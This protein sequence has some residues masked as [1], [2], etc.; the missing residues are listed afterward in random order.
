MFEWP[1]FK[2][3]TSVTYVKDPVLQAVLCPHECVS[4]MQSNKF[5]F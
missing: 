5:F 3:E 4:K 1:F 2:S